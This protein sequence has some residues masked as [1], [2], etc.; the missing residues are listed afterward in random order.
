[1]TETPEADREMT[2]DEL[3]D[4]A[5]GHRR[6]MLS[7]N[8]A[9]GDD[10]PTLAL[11]ADQRAHQRADVK[12]DRLIGVLEHEASESVAFRTRCTV[13]PPSIE[14]PLRK[15][16]MLG[17]FTGGFGLFVLLMLMGV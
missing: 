16:F 1:M 13:K 12:L 5:I 17:V 2:S 4:K 14:W 3:Y 10:V 6:T 15:M 9:P 8:P 11:M 7:L